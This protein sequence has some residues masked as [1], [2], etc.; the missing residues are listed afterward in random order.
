[1]STLILYFSCLGLGGIVGFTL[2][3]K[4]MN[5]FKHLGKL[6]ILCTILLMFAMG[7]GIGIDKD[8]FVS[9]P[10][11][12]MLSIFY[13]ISMLV[14]TFLFVFIVRKLLKVSKKGELE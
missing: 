10:V 12:G 13:A 1:M 5:K 2:K 7:V 6:Q 9:L 8:V 4:G 3:K 11:I 14:F